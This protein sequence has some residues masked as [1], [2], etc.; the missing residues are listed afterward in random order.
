MHQQS[1]LMRK[2]IIRVIAN[3]SIIKSYHSFYLFIF[4][5]DICPVW[6][7]WL[8]F[9]VSAKIFSNNGKKKERKSGIICH[10]WKDSMHFHFE[11]LYAGLKTCL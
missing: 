5:E 2:K 11:E 6:A 1:V 10:M 9:K 8:E 4:E 3:N 7:D